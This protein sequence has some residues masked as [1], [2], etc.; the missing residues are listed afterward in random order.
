MQRKV[1]ATYSLFLLIAVAILFLSNNS[2]PPNGYTGAP[3]SGQT[4]ASCHGGGS[5]SGN[6]AITGLPA[7]I[8]PDQI[9][10]ITVTVTRT[11]G[12]PQKA[13]FQMT[14]LDGSNNFT[15]AFTS[16][17]AGTTIQ[18]TGGIFYFEH[19]PGQSFGAGNV[20][21]FTVNWRA[22]ATGSGPI[23]LY[24][25][26]NLVNN[27]NSTTGDFVTTTVASG[28]LD[29]TGGPIIPNVSSTPVTCF[30]GSNGTAT[31]NPTGGG[32]GPYSYMWSTGSMQQSINNLSAG[33]YF[34]TVM[35][36]I[37]DMTV[38]MTTIS[39]PPQLFVNITASGNISCAN[40]NGFATAQA[41]GGVPGYTY[42][43]S[44]GASGAS[45]VFSNPGTYFVTATDA[46]QCPVVT[47]VTITANTTPPA[48]FAGPDR[49]ISCTSPTA[50]L[51]GAGS[52]TGAGI[53]YLWTG[54]GIV[55]GG[56]TLT[57]VVNQTGTYTLAVTNQS[58]G[59]T[60]TD[61]VGVTGSTTPPTANAGPDRVLT[62]TDMT[63]VL[64]GGGSSSGA[65]IT[66]SWTGPGIVSGGATNMPVVNMAG[67]YTLTVTN[68]TNSCVATDQV[69]VTSN[70][71]PPTANAGADM[72]ISCP[73]PTRTL[74]G[75]GST[76]GANI[77]YSWT[78]PG[79]VS[80]GAT[81]TPVVNA[82][83]TYIL[84]VTNQTNGCS[85]T[86]QV[87]VSGST[88]PPIASAGPGQTL[89]CLAT[90]VTLNGTGSSVG[91]NITYLWSG[92]GIVSGGTTTSPVV[93]AAGTYTLT[94][95]NQTNLCTATS[96][97]I[98]TGN[99]TLPVANAGTDTSIACTN[100]EVQLDGSGSSSGAN[101]SYAWTG[102][103][104]VS[105]DTTT[106]PVVN[107]AGVYT[108]TVT[109][110]TNGCLST[111]SVSVTANTAP[112]TADAGA[113]MAITCAN[114]S[115]TLNGGGSASGPNITYAWSGPGIV[116]GGTTTTPLVNAV[117]TYTLTVMN[118]TNGCSASDQV[119]VGSNTTLPT[120]NAGPG[121][122]LTCAITSVT[123][124]GTG[125]SA[126]ANIVYA[127][128]GPGI[129]SG[130]ATASPV[131]NVAGTYTLT[132]TNQTS[133]CSA[134]NQVMVQSD[135]IA[136][137]ANAGADLAITC[138]NTTVTLN[139]NSSSVGA[140]I[141]Y[142]WSGPGIV[143]GGTTTTPV[144][145]LGGT[146][147]L[148]VTNQTNGCSATDQTSV[149]VNTALGLDVQTT[150]ANCF[151]ASTG[152]A[153]A[154][155]SGGNGNYT[156]A[157]STDGTTAQITGLAAG[158]YSVTA[159]NG[160]CSATGSAAVSQP[161]V[162]VV[163]V[164]TTAETAPGA[165]DGSATAMA[166][167]GTP[168]YTFV[169]STGA[170]TAAIT[171]L[172]P[173][174]YSVTALDS[175]GCTVSTSAE[176]N[177]SI[178]SG[179]AVALT[180]ADMVCQDDMS[181][182]VAAVV[183]GGTEP[184]TFE[185]SNGGTESQIS[186]LAAS[187]YSVS[188]TDANNCNLTASAAV[189]LLPDLTPPV[190]VA[191]ALTVYLSVA[192]EVEITPEMADNGSLDNCG[193][194]EWQLSQSQFLCNETGVQ[195]ITLTAIDAAGN[196]AMADLLVTVLDTIA[197]DF[198]CPISVNTIGCNIVL[199]YQHPPV[200]ELCGNDLV[201]IPIE[202]T[203]GLP[204]GSILPF[205]ETVIT[206]TA[207]DPSGNSTACS[208]SVNVSNIPT[209]AAELVAPLCSGS[210]DGSIF[211]A[212]SGDAAGHSYQ[213]DDPSGQTDSIAVGL[214]AGIYNVIISGNSNGCVD[215]FTYTLE[216]PT[217]VEITLDE[218]VAELSTE[219]NG[220]ISV[221]AS[222]GQ[223]EPYTY[224]WRFNGQVFSTEE[225]L[226]GLSMGEYLLTVVDF[227]GCVALDTFV[228]DRLTNTLNPVSDYS[229]LLYPN[230]AED[231]LY[232]QITG[233]KAANLEVALMD[234][235]GRVLH[236]P[237]QIFS[238][239]HTFSV[240]VADYVPGVY[241]ARIIIGEKVLW[242]KVVVE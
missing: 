132:V 179:F 156:Y 76:S 204:I 82:A 12:T 196:E 90:N 120:A 146:Y 168:D 19:N 186:G 166:T 18:S 139:G 75:T 149:V 47:S 211:L 113:D 119:V 56:T 229:L 212:P 85:A 111:D 167:G 46:N 55:S 78:G 176:V 234:L 138:G 153:T 159:T 173:G 141:F 213:W 71:A 115:V 65:N 230:P 238:A 161:A 26:A 231:M 189:A 127:W 77:T 25:A 116:S 68:Q 22:P 81:A 131:V 37:G 88:T 222:G 109:D 155:A 15:G 92:P 236:Q 225:D 87:L 199:D 162:L 118:Q 106:M 190:V 42:A 5:N 64:N 163:N 214:S 41:S 172:A 114:A 143:S 140:N 221:T 117:G 51:N 108:L 89:T 34:V 103:G 228:V 137:M 188:V 48:A 239:R 219:M 60:A 99:T 59:C 160:N 53:S 17:S 30:G 123:L 154:I 28:T 171:G 2:N 84:T 62:C 150:P 217:S 93:N 148:T 129:V 242:R 147:T 134:S 102:P 206:L 107:M 124:N 128:A 187:V 80:G 142:V 135:T 122:T 32:G 66:Y 170:T 144:V 169:W 220:A 24:A 23:T 112:P 203:A 191:Q 20:L 14:A 210:A 177:N 33:T 195:T 233:E 133:G 95:T 216:E 125:S 241:L 100:A 38:G 98:V 69:E 11:N 180:P 105:G 208:F 182:S 201:F 6:V 110:Q 44:T 61:Q 126:G 91:A 4:C 235:D 197:P 96:Q 72:T 207:T 232:L 101:I 181:G 9:Y 121:Q 193:I 136:P 1:P 43:W 74:N 202:V 165:S 205:G 36:G 227:N 70:T 151:G 104:I 79:I 86:D 226:T 21:N 164:L 178:C 94:V 184:F 209:P 158:T 174:T 183:T 240:N 223:G 200:V 237:V 57:P 198:D 175:Q 16:P 35:N 73:N 13:G 218:L 215:T 27:N 97:V 145:N 152:T 192:G 3:P 31:A 49:V 157:W 63:A 194:V 54:P 10:P 29:A 224:I 50:T 40:P 185:W 58:N 7:T 45:A 67:T 8:I 52:S 83:G 130:G 39:S